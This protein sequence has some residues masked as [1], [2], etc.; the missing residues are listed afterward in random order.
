M[1][2]L[3]CVQSPPCKNADD[4]LLQELRLVIALWKMPRQKDLKGSASKLLV[5]DTPDEPVINKV[6]A[7]VPVASEAMCRRLMECKGRSLK[8]VVDGKQKVVANC[9]GILTLGAVILRQKTSWTM[10]Q[11]HVDLHTSAVQLTCK[12]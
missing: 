3:V 9:Y 7:Y 11:N 4:T 1:L 12:L 6:Q 10:A 5:L 8:L 2:N